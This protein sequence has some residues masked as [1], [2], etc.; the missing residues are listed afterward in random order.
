MEHVLLFDFRF[1]FQDLGRD[2]FNRAYANGRKFVLKCLVFKVKNCLRSYDITK[3]ANLW[4]AYQS[5]IFF[6]YFVNYLRKRVRWSK[7]L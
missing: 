4:S 7:S 3:K 2:I 1:V 6:L 5:Y